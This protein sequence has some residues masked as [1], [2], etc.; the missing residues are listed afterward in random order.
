MDDRE[1]AG[2]RKYRYRWNG[3]DDDGSVVPDGIYRLRVVRRKEGRVVDS[4][5][6]V[7]VDTR[8]PRVSIASVEPNV[9]VPGG[10]REVRIRYR[11]PRNKAPE[12]RVFRTDDDVPRPGAPVPRRREPHRRLGRHRARRPARSRGLVLVQREGARPG[13]QQDRGAGAAIPECERRAAAHGRGGAL[14]HAAGPAGRGARRLARR[15]AGRAARAPLRLRALAAGVAAHHPQRPPPRRP[16][17]RPHPQRRAHRRLPGAREARGRA[18]R[19][20]AAGGGR[21]AAAR[22]APAGRG[23]SWCCPP[24]P[25]RA[26][27]SSTRTSTASP[28]PS[29]R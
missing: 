20:L 10:P 5:K 12:F 28:T 8:P 29:T 14:A 17:A 18:P 25:G 16:A 4:I 1:L 6:E 2:D 26:P 27:T 3:R 7:R 19:R 9:I 13:R 11:G 23:R 24:S 22:H 21:P 15:P